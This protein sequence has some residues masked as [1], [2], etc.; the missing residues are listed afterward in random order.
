MMMTR[1][2]L[3]AALL[4][5]VSLGAAA[6]AKSERQRPV[7]LGPVGTGP[8]SLEY[9]RRQLMGTWT[10]SKFEV[11]DSTGTLVPVRARA[12]L[13]YDDYGNLTIKGVLLEPM[14]GQTSV[15]DAPALAYAGKAMIDTQKQDLVLVGMEASVQPDPAILAKIGMDQRRHYEITDKQLTM[16]VRDAQ[17]HNTAR[18]TYTR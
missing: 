8:G 18:A 9:T 13:I 2:H 6:C 15:T 5:T 10:L 12:Q 1:R 7:G 4:V 16:T 3:L 11:A 14:P 17:G